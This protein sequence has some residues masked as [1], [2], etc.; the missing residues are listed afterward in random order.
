MIIAKI[1]IF[2]PMTMDVFNMLSLDEKADVVWSGTFL[3]DRIKDEFCIQLYSLPDF[4]VEVFYEVKA[5]KIVDF[6]PFTDKQAL[7]PY[8][9]QIKL[10]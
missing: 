2:G 5:N 6:R 10:I 9:A 8:L 7:V 4:Y 3:S 1:H